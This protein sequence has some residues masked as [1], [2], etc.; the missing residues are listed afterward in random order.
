MKTIP[1]TGLLLAA[2]AA[3]ALGAE[4]AK[5]VPGANYSGKKFYF[6]AWGGPGS[7]TA[8]N[9]RARLGKLA[10][11]GITDLL[12]GDGPE[13]LKESSGWARLSASAFMPGTG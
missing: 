1:F 10:D 5:T 4:F 12:P 3:L 8:A 7:G 9:Q 6:A 13:R 2:S 11:A